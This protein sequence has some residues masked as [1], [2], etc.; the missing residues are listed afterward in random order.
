MYI[1]YSLLFVYKIFLDRYYD[2][3][4]GGGVSD[5]RYYYDRDAYDRYPPSPYRG[6]SSGISSGG[7]YDYKNYRPWDETYR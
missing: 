7:Y 3:P 5:G 4:R 6:G 2:R 1:I